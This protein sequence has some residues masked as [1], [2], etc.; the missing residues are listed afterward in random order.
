MGRIL[1]KKE[2]K[3]AGEKIQLMWI[4]MLQQDLDGITAEPS[5]SLEKRIRDL[6]PQQEKVRAWRRHRRIVAFI[7]AL[8]CALFLWLAL[9]GTA[10][11]AVL[12]WFGNLLATQTE[13]LSEIGTKEDNS[14]GYY[15]ID[16]SVV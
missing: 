14:I 15:L 8:I 13:T 6:I 4:D 5:E 7:L 9:D 16:R 10:R 11:S 1:K 3:K 12:D 2:L